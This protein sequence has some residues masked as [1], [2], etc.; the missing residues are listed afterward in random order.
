MKNEATKFFKEYFN[1]HDEEIELYDDTIDCMVK[2]AESVNNAV[3]GEKIKGIELTHYKTDAS[4]N[5]FS[6]A[7]NRL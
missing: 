1:I 5:C 7:D 6:D 4:G 3:C 2:F